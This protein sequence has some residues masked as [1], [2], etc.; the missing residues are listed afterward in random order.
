MAADGQQ[1]TQEN[2]YSWVQCPWDSCNWCDCV[3]GCIGIGSTK[4]MC[5]PHGNK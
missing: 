3:N 2:N 1:C 5:I 4:A